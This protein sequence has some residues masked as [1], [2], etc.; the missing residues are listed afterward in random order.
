MIFLLKALLTGA[1][2]TYASWMDWKTLRV[3]NWIWLVLG[4]TGLLLIGWD[5]TNAYNTLPFNWF[6]G[7][8]AI[9]LISITACAAISLI[10]YFVFHVGGAD[11]KAI[12]C[13]G[14]LYPSDPILL[15]LALFLAFLCSMILHTRYKSIPFIPPLTLGYMETTILFILGGKI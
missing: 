7:H 2:L 4:A 8:L 11:S 10:A 1:M 13:L 9:M 3:D 14:L 6:V 5:I 12:I 15:F